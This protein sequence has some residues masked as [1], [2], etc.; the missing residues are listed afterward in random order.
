MDPA[1]ASYSPLLAEAAAG[2]DLVRDGLST[3]ERKV[4]DTA[5][6]RLFSNPAFLASGGG[7]TT[8]PLMSGPPPLR[9]VPP[10]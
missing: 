1:L 7:R 6:S 4:L 5:D 8:G 9:A 3:K 10:S 2:L